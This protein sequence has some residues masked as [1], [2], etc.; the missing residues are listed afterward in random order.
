METQVNISYRLVVRNPSYDAY[1]SVLI[2]LATFGK[3]MGMDTTRA[4]NGLR[5]PNPTKM[6]AHWVYLLG[7]LLSRN[8]VFEIFRGEPLLKS[9]TNFDNSV[10]FLYFS[11]RNDCLIVAPRFEVSFGKS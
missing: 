1:F 8:Y 7:Q 10:L 5:P 4:P 6:L 9:H 3:R 11:D 2:F